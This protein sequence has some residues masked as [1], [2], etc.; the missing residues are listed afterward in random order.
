V[1]ILSEILAEPVLEILETHGGRV[2]KIV[3]VKDGG[4]YISVMTVV[5]HVVT[6]LRFPSCCF[7]PCHLSEGELNYD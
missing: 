6:C 5:F 2:L 4:S 7:I 3:L 1:D